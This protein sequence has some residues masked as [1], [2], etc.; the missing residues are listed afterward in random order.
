MDKQFVATEKIDGANIQFYVTPGR[1]FKIGKRSSFIGKDTNFHHVL[2][3]IDD[4]KPFINDLQKY[5]HSENVNIRVFG[6]LFGEKIQRRIHYCSGH[7]ILFYDLDIEGKRVSQYEFYNFM[8]QKLD[9][10]YTYLT[11]PVLSID[12]LEKLLEFDVESQKSEVADTKDQPIEGIVLKPMNE[13]LKS[14][15]GDF[16]Y[17]KKKTEKFSEIKAKKK[18]RP[19]FEN[20]ILENFHNTFLT[21]INEPRVLSTFS[22]EGE[23]EKPQ[24]IADYIRWVLEDAKEDFITDLSNNDTETF[25]VL[26]DKEKRLIFNVGSAIVKILKKYL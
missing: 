15:V 16:M 4:Y 26:N 3:I 22:K 17:I 10:D 5:S 12:S 13:V 8:E 19:K 11:V 23:I 21:Y 24:Q 25:K 2:E 6:E 1:R 18:K 7:K 9:N 14:A 20:P